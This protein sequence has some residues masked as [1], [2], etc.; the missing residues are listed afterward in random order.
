[1]G[2]RFQPNGT[3]LCAFPNAKIENNSDNAKQSRPE[4]SKSTNFH[5]ARHNNTATLALR[6]NRHTTPQHFLNPTK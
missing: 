4:I 6:N 1:M 3:A 2:K 5:A